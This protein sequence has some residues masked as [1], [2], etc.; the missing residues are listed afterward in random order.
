MLKLAD[1]G[2]ARTYAVPLRPYTHEV[3]TLWYRSPEILLGQTH[4]ST[5][6]DV[7]SAGCIF[8]EMATGEPF[9]QG[10][11]EIDQLFKIFSKLGSPSV[12]V[13]PNLPNLP[14]YMLNAPKFRAKVR[15]P[16]WHRPQCGSCCIRG[17]TISHTCPAPSFPDLFIPSLSPRSAVEPL[18]SGPRRARDRPPLAHAVL[19]PRKAHLCC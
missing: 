7:W 6:V 15:R 8:A 14:D 17:L 12:D 1:F 9:F 4:Y 2:L 18:N 5:A 13:W 11:S 3:V 19:R 16:H 10:D